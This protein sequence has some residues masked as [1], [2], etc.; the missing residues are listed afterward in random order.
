[1]A[2]EGVQIR[3]LIRRDMDEVLKIE[4]ASFALP[5]RLED[6]HSVLRQ[7]KGI[8]MVAE[9][10]GRVVGFMIYLLHKQ[11]LEIMDFAVAPAPRRRGI[12]AA[13]VRRMQDKFSFLQR[14][15][16]TLLCREGNLDAL[17][18]F[19]SQGFRAV[20]ILHDHYDG[21]GEDAYQMRYR[22]DAPEAVYAPTNR[23]SGVYDD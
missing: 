20:G 16:I 4:D 3:W 6:F 14:T 15:E 11:R 12:G 21:S 1:M 18:F 22:L 13:M 19:R 7:A 10:A 8:G 9:C 23:I 2:P 17:A 5:W